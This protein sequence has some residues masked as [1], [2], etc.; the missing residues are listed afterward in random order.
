M[1]LGVIVGFITAYPANVWMVA[2]RLKHGLMTMRD[3]MKPAGHKQH[4]GQS[5]TA[6][7]NH[8]GKHHQMEL[9]ATVP[10][11]AA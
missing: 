3:G 10:Q 2:F 4:D 7:H 1:S 11:L 8:E 5:K 9:D 6:G